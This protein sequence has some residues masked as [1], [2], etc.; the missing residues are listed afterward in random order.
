MV[1]PFSSEKSLYSFSPE[2]L[3]TGFG[4]ESHLQ[5][6]SQRTVQKYRKPPNEKENINQFIR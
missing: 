6:K 5:A 3:A 1:S 4:S 2:K